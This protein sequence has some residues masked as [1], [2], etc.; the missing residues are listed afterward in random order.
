[1]STSIDEVLKIIDEGD[2]E[3]FKKCD[4]PLMDKSIVRHCILRKQW[5]ILSIYVAL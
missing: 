5:T 1:M 3:G 2:I 4:V